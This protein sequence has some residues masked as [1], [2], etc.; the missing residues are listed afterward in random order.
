ME[1]FQVSGSEGAE[2]DIKVQKVLAWKALNNMGEI[3]TS[4]M[5]KGLKLRFFHATVETILL[6]RRE[7]WILT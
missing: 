5:S 7:A 1:D 6:Y 2:N 4:Q 3:W